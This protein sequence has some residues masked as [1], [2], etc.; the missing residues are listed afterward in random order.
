[1]T[2][3]RPLIL[4][5][6]FTL[7]HLEA[8][9]GAIEVPGR[10]RNAY[11]SLNVVERLHDLQNRFALVLA[12]ARSWDGT[13][14]VSEGLG[15]HGVKVSGLVMEDGAL[16]GAPEGLYEWEPERDWEELRA[17]IDILREPDWPAFEWQYDFMACLVARAI[18][19]EQA[20]MLMDTLAHQIGPE[21][22][23][24]LFRDGR[25]VYLLP[26]T[27]DKWSA[28]QKL[29]G[30]RAQGAAG[31]GD[32]KNDLCWL[33]QIA[34]PATFVEGDATIIECVRSRGGFVSTQ[35]GHQ[36]IEEI[37]RQI[38]EPEA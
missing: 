33:Q 16:W 24:R 32:G 3:L 29:L 5:L 1:M 11:L 18:D 38:S 19:R 30:E 15:Q 13:R 26:R 25:K 28:L 22:G 21:A 12:T 27:A 31:V 37:L 17:A 34:R 9:P 6:D 7:I 35:R 20:S 8:L 4:D 36:G 10:T 14:W 23:L 2:N